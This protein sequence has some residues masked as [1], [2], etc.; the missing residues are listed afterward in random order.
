[1]QTRTLT[2]DHLRVYSELAQDIAKPK[3]TVDVNVRAFYS[4]GVEVFSVTQDWD[5]TGY[6]GCLYR[7]TFNYEYADPNNRYE[8]DIVESSWENA[9]TVDPT[10]ADKLIED[11]EDSTTYRGVGRGNE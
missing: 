1:M 11:D 6:Y 7:L 8:M 9:L 4:E 3:R 10:L 2:V 5:D